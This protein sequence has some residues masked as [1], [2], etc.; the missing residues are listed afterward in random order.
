LSITSKGKRGKKKKCNPP[1]EIKVDP[2]KRRY[3][4]PPNGPSQSAR[5][6]GGSI[7]TGPL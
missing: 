3:E 5:S 7:Y 1:N 4:L 2:L 6:R